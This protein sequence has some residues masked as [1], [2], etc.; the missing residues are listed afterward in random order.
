MK[1]LPL[2]LLLSF[3]SNAQNLINGQPFPQQQLNEAIQKAWEQSGNPLPQAPATTGNHVKAQPSGICHYIQQQTP[4]AK[5][6]RANN[7]KSG[8]NILYVGATSHDTLVVTG[9]WQYNGPVAV[10]ND[11]VL[12]FNNANATISGSLIVTGYG[13]VLATN[14][15]FLFPQQYFYEWGLQGDSHGLL[16]MRHCT[17]DFNQTATP[18]GMSDSATFS[19]QNVYFTSNASTIGLNGH[20]RFLVDTANL[21]GEIVATDSIQ[22]ILQ[23]VDTVIVWHHLQ[24]GAGL[25]WTFPNGYQLQHYAIGPDSAGVNGLGYT[26]ELDNIAQVHWAVMPENLT[27][28]NISNSTI[29]SVAVICR[30]TETAMLQGLVD[31]STYITSPTFFSDRTFQ[32]TNCTVQTWGVYPTDTTYVDISSC[33]L[34]EIGTSGHGHTSC[35]SMLADG[36]GGYYWASGFGFQAASGCGF[37]CSLRA[38]QGGIALAGFSSVTASTGYAIDSGILF[39]IQTP[40]FTPPIAYDGSDIWVGMLAPQNAADSGYIVSF[41]GSAYILRGPTSHLMSFASYYVAYQHAG[42]NTWTITDSVHTVP[43]NQGVVANW[44]TTGALTG[45]YNMQMI[46]KDNF[47]DSVTVPSGLVIVIG[48]SAS[49]T[50]TT[51]AATNISTGSAQ[52]N[53]TVNASSATISNIAFNWGNTS[54]YGNVVNATPGSAS[55]SI[56]FSAAIL[57]LQPNHTYYFQ[58]TATANGVTIYGLQQQFTTTATGVSNIAESGFKIYPNPSTGQLFIETGG[59]DI[60][61]INIYN[62]TGGLVK[63]T[64]QLQ[65]NSIDISHLANGVYVIEIITKDARVMRRWAK[66]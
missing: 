4:E 22:L 58:A 50:I 66:M 18:W 2:L 56:G 17:L 20:A 49:D 26:I 34:G 16:Q 46:I 11:G 6:A 55:T 7:L 43:V 47:G 12:I 62:S 57:G 31:K 30:G 59:A 45:S 37:I 38:E 15:Y 13:Q 32:L 19:F 39:L 42:D 3:F 1:L 33:I 60:T 48:T 52:L 65:N 23:N 28:V 61:G 51:T 44:N 10:I 24:R 40:T 53:G 5:A 14:S 9:N 25:T 27:T 64:M 54:A 21:L 35:S 36:T 8:G 29:R 63:Q 41:T